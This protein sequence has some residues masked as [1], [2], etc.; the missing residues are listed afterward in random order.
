[1][2]KLCGKWKIIIAIVCILLSIFQL[3]TAGFG[4]LT[5]R[6]QRGIH[7]TL[8][9]AIAFILFPSSKKKKNITTSDVIFSVLSLIV[10]F[11]VVLNNARLELRWEHVTEVLPIEVIFG[12]IAI[13]LVLEATRRTVSPVLSILAGICLIYLPIGPYLEGILNDRNDFRLTC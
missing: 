5:T 3:Y 10:G 1:M 11:Y 9:L 12:T 6:L 2:R 8:V 4:V 13:L 7:I